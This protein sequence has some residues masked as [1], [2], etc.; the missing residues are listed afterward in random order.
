MEKAAAQRWWMSV[1]RNFV[2]E[3]FAKFY[4]F[5]MRGHF[6]A[7]PKQCWEQEPT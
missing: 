4:N 6:F 2:R 1:C 5:S 3:I 7:I